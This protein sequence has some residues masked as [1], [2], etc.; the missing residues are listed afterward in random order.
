MSRYTLNFELLRSHGGKQRNYRCAF[1]VSSS[2]SVTDSI[3]AQTMH[4]H[5]KKVAS[6]KNIA[7]LTPTEACTVAANTYLRMH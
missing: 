2:R 5:K 3:S 7:K 6:F 1:P 4:M